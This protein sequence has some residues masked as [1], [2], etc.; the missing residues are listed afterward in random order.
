MRVVKTASERVRQKKKKMSTINLHLLREAAE[1]LRNFKCRWSSL[2][3]EPDSEHARNVCVGTEKKKKKR[4]RNCCFW[5]RKVGKF[6]WNKPSMFIWRDSRKFLHKDSTLD[7]GGISG[8]ISSGRSDVCAERIAAQ[9]LNPSAC[10]FTARLHF[11][12]WR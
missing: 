4:C 3:R 7:K 10:V 5:K 8:T 1:I 6:V 9:R 11:I 2:P 12:C